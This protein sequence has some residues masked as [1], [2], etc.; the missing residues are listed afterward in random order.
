[1]TIAMTQP[2]ENPGATHLAIESV[3]RTA[4]KTVGFLYLFAMAVSIFGESVRGRLILPH[5][6]VQTASSIAASEALFRLSIVGDLIIY[7]CD[8]VLFWGLYVILK[9]V[10]KDVALLA[11]FFRLV[12]TAILGVTTLTAF[13]ALRLLSGADYLRV[14]DIA[15][16]QALARGFLSVYGI[17]LSVGFVFLGLGSAVFSYLWLKS[18]YIP[19]GIAGLGIFASLLMA[20]MS[21]VTMVFPVVWDRVGIAYM[22]PMGLYEVGL[23]FW[24]LVKG[25][26]PPSSS[27]R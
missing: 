8:I 15:Q 13:I 5:D 4:A 27:T 9:R 12:E 23:G 14:V 21:L 20:I 1:M 6:A 25:I 10:N 3:Q 19:R 18:R 16:L 26:R 11:V 24:L 2:S 17:G 22:M 7:V